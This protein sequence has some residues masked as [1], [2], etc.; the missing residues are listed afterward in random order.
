MAASAVSDLRT[1]RM[2]NGQQVFGLNEN[3]SLMVYRDIF[4]DDCYRQHGVTIKDGDCILD[5]GANTGLFILFL[6]QICTEARVFAFE[7]LPAT[8]RALQR[9]VET[10]NKLSVQLF[11]VGL[12]DQSGSAD[13][14]YYPR[15][16]NASTMYPDDPARTA[17]QG[18]DY[19]L[20]QIDTLPWPHCRIAHWLP[21]VIQNLIADQ[22]AKHYLKHESVR[23]ELWTLADFLRRHDIERIDLLKLDA[24]HAEQPILAGLDESD[25]PKIRQIVVEVHGGPEAD[26]AMVALLGRRGFRTAVERN[27]ALPSLALVYATRP[28]SG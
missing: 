6:N 3:D 22:I 17:Q 9:N 12:S 19:V 25:W 16:T 2:P 26:E 11:N 21:S 10:L 24:E 18:R 20:T 13:F 1:F 23:C 15:L 8:F 28:A 4:D 7:P 27:P 5:I 14:V